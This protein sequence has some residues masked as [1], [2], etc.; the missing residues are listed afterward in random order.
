MSRDNAKE[1]LYKQLELLAE[2]SEKANKTGEQSLLPG[3]T[4]EMVSI[5]RI[6]FII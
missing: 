2:V 6:L 3:L 4:G 5:Y 1:I